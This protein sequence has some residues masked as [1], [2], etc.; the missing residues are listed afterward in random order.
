LYLLARDV[1]GAGKVSEVVADL[2]EAMG[3]TLGV[4]VRWRGGIEAEGVR[5][6]TPLRIGEP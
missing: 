1:G 6:L 3:E 4:R 2:R 5:D